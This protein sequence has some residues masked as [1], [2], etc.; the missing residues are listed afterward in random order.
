MLDTLD[1]SDDF[2]TRVDNQYT[3]IGYPH[4]IGTSTT[5]GYNLIYDSFGSPNCT[6]EIVTVG[7]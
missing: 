4:S 3:L 7:C 2:Q 1:V 6:V 5:E